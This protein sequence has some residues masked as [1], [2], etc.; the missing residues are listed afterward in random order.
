MKID[1]EVS[2]IFNATNYSRMVNFARCTLNQNKEES[3]CLPG[4][5]KKPSP[6]PYMKKPLHTTPDTSASNQII[7]NYCCVLSKMFAL[8][9]KSR[10]SLGNTAKFLTPTDVDGEWKLLILFSFTISRE[11]TFRRYI[12]MYD[13]LICYT[14]RTL[15]ILI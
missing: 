13:Y 7:C 9:R 1:I 15:T 11:Y 14:V 3:H 4:V 8:C 6:F 12:L 2:G 5:V 10:F